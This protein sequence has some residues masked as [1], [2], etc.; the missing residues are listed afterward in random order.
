MECV[1]EGGEEGEEEEGWDGFVGHGSVLGL[2]GD[3]S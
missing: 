3:V 2:G 1:G